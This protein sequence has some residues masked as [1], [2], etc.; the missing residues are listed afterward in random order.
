MEILS[1]AGSY[2]ALKSAVSAGA[3]AVYFGSGSFNARINAQNFNDNQ[4]CQAVEY[5]H[6]NGVLAYATLNTLINDTEINTALETVQ[7]F[8][9]AGID[10]FIVQDAGL[11]SLLKKC[12][13]IPIHASTQM[14]VHSLDGVK[15]LEQL[16]FTRVVLAREL[17]KAD[18]T[19]ITQN[20]N[21]ETEVFVHGAL[22][23]CYSGQCYM[24][25]VIGSRSANRGQC[26]QP[27]RLEYQHG[28]Q[29][30]LKDLCLLEYVDELVQIGVSSLKIEG[31]M[32]SPEYVAAVTEQYVHK[33]DGGKYTKENKDYLAKVFSRD[34]FTDNYYNNI[35]KK[36]MFGTK[37]TS[38]IT[39]KYDLK[40][41]KKIKISFDIEVTENNLKIF[42]CDK[43]ITVNIEITTEKAENQPTTIKILNENLLKLGNTP[44]FAEKIEKD[45]P[46][47]LYIPISKINN[48]RRELC[49][50]LTQNRLKNNNIFNKIEIKKKQVQTKP[51]N[52]IYEIQVHDIRQ[53]PENLEKISKIWLPIKDINNI[54]FEKFKNKIGIFLPR[55]FHDSEQNDIENKLKL[56]KS[57]GITDILCPNIGH[58]ELCKRFGLTIHGDYGLN[59]FNAFSANE[60]K[61]LG[62]KTL[63]ASFELNLIKIQD[64][65]DENIGILAYGRLPFMITKNCIKSKHNT[66]EI[67]TDRIK[68][69]FLVTCE[70]GCRNAVWNANV[71]FLAD[72]DIKNVAFQRL[73]FT[74][75]NK[76]Q[77][78]KII[79]AYTLKTPIEIKDFTRGLY[80]KTI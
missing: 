74:D 56:I 46:K 30:S 76:N 9:N 79:D 33:K 45:L 13:N 42:A 68:K 26:A 34:G 38:S 60:Y 3:D 14:S 6:M 24:S 7:N 75:E 80:Y 39:H 59:V 19:Y 12:T 52:D 41:Y 23:M 25:S 36:D 54:N 67:L 8:S 71:L 69:E 15:A 57:F 31:R 35:I 43:N 28:Y 47:D 50:K 44:F 65:A 27:C 10:A 18:I 4:I 64:F 37:S 16:G 51:I 1:P 53:I 66:P 78:E 49:E 11:A 77:A 40:P 5:A 72:K 62:F 55:I 48:A 61:N 32:K 2:E 22:C 70:Y 20:A 17:S 21:I 63:T 73:V 58:A 29:L